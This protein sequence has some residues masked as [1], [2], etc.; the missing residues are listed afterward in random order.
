MSTSLGSS[1]QHC[2]VERGVDFPSPAF[3]FP[4]WKGRTRVGRKITALP[5]RALYYSTAAE[6]TEVEVE[7]EE[8]FVVSRGR[9]GEGGEGKIGGREKEGSPADPCSAPHSNHFWGRDSPKVFRLDVIDYLNCTGFCLRCFA[10]VVIFAS[11]LRQS[12]SLCS[13]SLSTPSSDSSLAHLIKHAVAANF[14]SAP[15]MDPSVTETPHS[16]LFT[17]NTATASKEGNSFLAD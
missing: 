9:R 3:P 6:G 8:E 12:L 17:Q 2:D 16:I 10:K 15:I 7:E 1:R 11:G 13:P 5:L 4:D 14:R